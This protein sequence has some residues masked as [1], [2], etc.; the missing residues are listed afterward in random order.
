MLPVSMFVKTGNKQMI[1]GV[2]GR[3]A[4]KDLNPTTDTCQHHADVVLQIKN[5]RS[6]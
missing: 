4:F 2:I 6:H 1:G 5:L 3:K